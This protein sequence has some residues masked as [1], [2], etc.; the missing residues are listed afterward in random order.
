MLQ[1]K[2]VLDRQATIGPSYIDFIG[3]PCPKSTEAAEDPD[4]E[5]DTDAEFD[6]NLGDDIGRIN[7]RGKR[8]NG[9][10]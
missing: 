6:P 4:T 9:Y 10:P 5:A 2:V 7:K 8:T 1:S 3:A